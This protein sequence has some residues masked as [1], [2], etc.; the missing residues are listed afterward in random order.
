MGRQKRG[1]RTLAPSRGVAIPPNPELD[2]HADVIRDLG[3]RSL[4]NMLEIGRRLKRCREILKTQRAY[5]AW[6][7]AEFGWSHQHCDRA[8]TLFENRGK[9]NKMLKMGVSISGLALLTKA[10]EAAFKRVQRRVEAGERMRVRDVRDEVRA[11]RLILTSPAASDS[12]PG[13]RFIWRSDEPAT[14]GRTI[15]AMD[16][17][18]AEAEQFVRRL[19]ELRYYV[20]TSSPND[21]AEV[22]S[23]GE[24]RAAVREYVDEVA[25]WL[26]ALRRALRQRKL[27][28]VS[29]QETMKHKRF[30]S[31]A[32][33]PPARL[34]VSRAQRSAD[35]SARAARAASYQ[36][37]RRSRFRVRP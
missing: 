21:I 31:A 24:R 8:I 17:A 34:R 25:E 28:A 37:V 5:M 1:R 14:P 26:E 23:S 33:L 19:E 22:L 13:P 18:K 16:L 6:I 32:A 7:R 36:S 20:S 3:R 27:S 10:S 12:G 2:E 29:D 11:E 9:F 30:R 4:D 15:T 35:P